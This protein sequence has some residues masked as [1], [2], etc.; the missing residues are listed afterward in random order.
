MVVTNPGFS[1]KILQQ[2][3]IPSPHMHAYAPLPP[4]QRNYP[5][6]DPLERE[7]KRRKRKKQKKKLDRRKLMS[8]MM[9]FQK[10][11]NFILLMAMSLSAAHSNI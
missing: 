2:I 4:S 6:H 11:N 1:S 9:H 3:L 5:L 8:S 7:R 10:P